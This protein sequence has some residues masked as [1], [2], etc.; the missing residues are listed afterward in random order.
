MKIGAQ[1]EQTWIPQKKF[2]SLNLKKNGIEYGPYDIRRELENKI[3]YNI[4]N[5]YVKGYTDTKED[6][7]YSDIEGFIVQYK[8][9]LDAGNIE[10]KDAEY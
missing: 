9:G 1:A 4:V 2:V 6:I 8:Q 5:A 10:Y 3:D 7:S